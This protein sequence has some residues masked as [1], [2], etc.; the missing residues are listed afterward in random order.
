MNPWLRPR[1]RSSSV[2]SVNI[3]VFSVDIRLLSWPQYTP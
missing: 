1:L 3:A 2:L